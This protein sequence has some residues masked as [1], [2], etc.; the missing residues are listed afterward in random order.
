MKSYGF[1]VL[2]SVAALADLLA[3]GV[4]ASQGMQRLVAVGSPALTQ[5][6]QALLA[7]ATGDSQK[8]QLLSVIAE[9]GA[10]HSVGPLLQAAA[11][12]PDGLLYGPVLMALAQLP[13]S[14]RSVAFAR[15]QLA[16]GIAPAWKAA[17][18]IYLGRIR[19]APALPSV[20]EYSAA[21]HPLQVRAAALYLGARLGVAGMFEAATE[22]LQAQ[23]VRERS[24]LLRV[25]G[26]AAPSVAA[27]SETAM[28]F[29]WHARSPD[30]QQMIAYCAF[31]TSEP[32][33]RVR[34]AYPLL[35]QPD[36]EFRRM[37][38]R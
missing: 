8:L 9:I 34:F 4:S 21:H 15:D 35:A 36:P 30:L 29:G 22:R 25:L 20:A 14:E 17:A 27:L 23:P 38:M 7:P 6:H 16:D 13:A 3:G 18:L 33:D 1:K 19:Y 10:P 12:R 5:L 2:P 28:M 24:M 26:E 31:R 37:A 11:S 32:T